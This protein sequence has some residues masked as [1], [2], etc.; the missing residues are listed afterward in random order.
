MNIKEALNLKQDQ[1]KFFYIL[2][3][4]NNTD[5]EWAQRQYDLFQEDVLKIEKYI[6]KETTTL[7]LPICDFYDRYICMI[8]HNDTNF[9]CLKNDKLNCPYKYKINSTQPEGT[10]GKVE[11]AGPGPETSPG[12]SAPE[13]DQAGPDQAP[14][15]EPD[16][17]APEGDK[18]EPPAIDHVTSEVQ[19]SNVNPPVVD[20][21]PCENIETKP[22]AGSIEI[23]ESATQ[24]AKLF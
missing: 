12:S 14:A 13:T 20:R 22:S 15:P 8:K 10:T 16:Q 11:A 23:V 1:V 21:D 18:H 7:D 9:T 4:K 2:L 19:G 17:N 5:K 6:K 24:Q 3:M